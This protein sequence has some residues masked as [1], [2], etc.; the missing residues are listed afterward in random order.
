MREIPDWQHALDA[1]SEVYE[2]SASERGREMAAGWLEDRYGRYGWN[3]TSPSANAFLTVEEDLQK[4][5]PLFITREMQELTYEAM[6]TFNRD[7][8]LH[9]D[10]IFIPEGFALLETPFYS[11][12]SQ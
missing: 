3:A 1:L 7:E 11:L 8:P 10:D 9:F 12:D 5:E 2:I 4:A 6:E